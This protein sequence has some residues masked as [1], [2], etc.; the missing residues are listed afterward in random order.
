MDYWGCELRIEK[1]NRAEIEVDTALW[2]SNFDCLEQL[3]PPGTVVPD[4]GAAAKS[5]AMRAC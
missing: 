5:G 3:A 2:M 1:Y 4:R